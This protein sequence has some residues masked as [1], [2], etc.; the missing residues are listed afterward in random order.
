MSLR[1]SAHCYP[2]FINM[3]IFKFVCVFEGVGIVRICSSFRFREV[4]SFL[5]L[6]STFNGVS[7]A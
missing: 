4:L 3:L 7:I 1:H 6:L 5:K 2:F